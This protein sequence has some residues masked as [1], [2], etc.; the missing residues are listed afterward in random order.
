MLRNRAGSD[1]ITAVRAGAHVGREEF[2]QEHGREEAD[3]ACFF[4]EGHVYICEFGGGQR[5]AGGEDYMV[6]L[7]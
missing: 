3:H 5:V 1:G 4:D 7:V 6:Q 2:P